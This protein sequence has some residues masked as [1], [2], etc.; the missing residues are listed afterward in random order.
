MTTTARDL[1]CAEREAGITIIRL[2]REY[3]SVDCQTLAELEAHLRGES[4]DFPA[5]L[6]IDLGETT[7]IGC[8]LLSVLLRCYVR[9]REDN[10]RFALCSLNSLP[11][12]VLATTHLNS[13]WEIFRTRREAIEAMQQPVDN[14]YSSDGSRLWRR[15]DVLPDGT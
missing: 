9:V 11:E 12:S 15:G 5:G 10:C 8:G 7:Y 6:L 1:A 2:R 4:D 3:G 14:D 13:L